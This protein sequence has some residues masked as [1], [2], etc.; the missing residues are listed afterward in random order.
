MK[1]LEIGVHEIIDF[2]LRKG[3]IDNRYFN[4][5]TM[6]EGTRLHKY[7]QDKQGED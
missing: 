2:I 4:E 3:D 5:T 1:V 6:L 7:Y